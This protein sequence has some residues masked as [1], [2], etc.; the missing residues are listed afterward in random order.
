MEKYTDVLISCELFDGISQ[1]DLRALLHCLNA[2]VRSYEKSAF[3]FSMGDAVTS[4]G[5]VL[6]GAAHVIK[7]DYWGARAILAHIE[8]GGLFGE[9]FT[10]AGIDQLPLSVS[11]AEKTEVLL[12]DYRRIIQTCSNACNFHTRLVMNMLRL[13]ARKNIMLTQKIEVLT[14]KTTREKLLS[15]LSAQAIHAGSSRFQIPFNRQALADYLS[16]ERSAMSA[17]LSKMQRDGLIKTDRRHFEL[18]D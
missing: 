13:L 8:P 6:S 11:A 12:I 3:I 1:D 7:E 15:Y 10:C 17:E 16:V 4:I 18:L 9:A 14:R 2:H 5:I